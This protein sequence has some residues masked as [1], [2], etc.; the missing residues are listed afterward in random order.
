MNA[1]KNEQ[2]PSIAELYQSREGKVSDKWELYLR[3]YERLLSPYRDLPISLLEIGIQNGGS[4]ERWAQYMPNAKSLI[5]CDINEACRALRYDDRRISVVVGDA[6]APEIAA[7]ILDHTPA[8]DIVI[9]DGSHR[10]SD[11]IKSFAKFFPALKEGGVF[12]AEDLHCSYWK[13]YEGGLSYP[14]SAIAFFKRLADIVSH[15]HWGVPVP[16]AAI[17]EPFVAAYGNPLDED[18]LATIHSVEFV[19]SICVVTKRRS[20]LNTLGR[21][22]VSGQEDIVW[23]GAK[24]LHLQPHVPVVEVNNEW[25]EVARLPEIER[26]HLLASV[27]ALGD[28]RKELANRLLKSE[29]RALAAERRENELRAALDAQQAAAD[30]AE[31]AHKAVVD[32][33][34]RSTSWRITAPLRRIRSLLK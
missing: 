24:A 7:Q 16:R 14:L 22:I 26:T 12:I 17:L 29:E 28:E 6:N 4:L 34:R 8:F 27:T 18:T 25:N 10:S 33:F 9:D 32:E 1:L 21:R 19:N 20:D 11:I 3:E 15:E 23:Q 2:M 30:Q 13:D 31:S 5:G